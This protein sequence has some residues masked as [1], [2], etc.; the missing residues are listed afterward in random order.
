MRPESIQTHNA[1]YCSSVPVF[2]NAPQD[3]ESGTDE[4]TFK[5][6]NFSHRTF[7]VLKTKATNESP[8]DT[9]CDFHVCEEL[10]EL[11]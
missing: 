5:F 1:H 2:E 4:I 10:L 8:Q 7:I 6:F 3:D 9:I 11:S